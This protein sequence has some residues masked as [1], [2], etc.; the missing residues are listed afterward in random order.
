M[1]LSKKTKLTLAIAPLA[2]MGCST[3]GGDDRRAVDSREALPALE[4]PPPLTTPDPDAAAY[5]PETASAR[6]LQEQEAKQPRGVLTETE[7][8]EIKRS[9]DVRW[10]AVKAPTA[11]VWSEVQDF[12]VEEGYAIAREDRTLGIIETRW[13]GSGGSRPDQGGLQALLLRA[14][15]AITSPDV[16]DKLKLRVEPGETAAS[17]RIYLAHRQVERVEED[18]L[19][20][21]GGTFKW[22]EVDPDPA[23]VNEMLVRLMVHLG[24]SREDATAQ[25]AAAELQ[26]RSK[27][28]YDEG[29]DE[30]HVEVQQAYSLVWN[31]MILALEELGF[32]I[33][34]KEPENGSVIASHPHPGQ[35]AQAGRL[36]EEQVREED[37]GEES[38]EMKLRLRHIDTGGVDIE[39]WALDDV[40]ALENSERFVGGLLE[41]R[42][43]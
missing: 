14:V 30:T 39:L 29:K 42:L 26:P 37:A 25:A 27:L 43:R 8:A 7:T 18:T 6:A 19:I 23:K 21:E 33:T 9:G 5:V 16:Q 2:I 1:F 31:R 15:S 4:V 41:E 34:E 38:L 22:E 40:S 24:V 3:F 36:T 17:S 10:L 20:D 13:S 11:E 12:L 28:V 35:L 32:D